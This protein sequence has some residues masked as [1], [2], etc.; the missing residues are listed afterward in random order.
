MSKTWTEYRTRDGYRYK[1]TVWEGE[2][3]SRI[4]KWE[5]LSSVQLDLFNEQD[6]Q[7]RI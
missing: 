4:A 5:R 1:V 3:G 2:Y 7:G 6:I